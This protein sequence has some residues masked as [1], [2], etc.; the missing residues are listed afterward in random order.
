MDFLR[1]LVGEA[2]V[3]FIDEGQKVTTIGQTVKLLVD[4][5]KQEKQVVVTGSSSIN[6]LDSVEESLTGRKFVYTLF[7]LSL[8]EIF[9]DKDLL[10]INK[11]L[12]TLMIFGSYP[13]VAEEKAFER[14][15]ELLRNL[16]SSYLYKDVLE[17][18]GIRNSDIIMKL[19]KYANKKATLTPP[20]ICI[21]KLWK[22]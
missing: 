16:Q 1:H 5:Y 17:F 19:V 20:A 11:E 22:C 4:F 21:R 14:K 13:E 3:I 9:P 10:A 15:I 2:K 18:Q 7:P 8:E 6:L 12:Q